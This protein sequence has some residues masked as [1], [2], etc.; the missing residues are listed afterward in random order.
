MIVYAPRDEIALQNI[1][2]IAQLGLDHPIAIRYPRGRGFI[3]DWQSQYLAKYEKIEIGKSICLK[4]GSQIAVLSCGTIGNNVTL[5]ISKLKHPQTIAH[6]DFSFVKPLDEI[7]LHSIFEKYESVITIEDGTVKGG[8]GSAI[9]EFAAANHYH[10]QIN[11][12]GIPDEFIE[13]GTV[14][15]LQQ[16]CKIDVESLKTLFSSY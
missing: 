2:Y 1:L 6:Y 16:L 10:S 3:T 5:A 13:H 8:F 15:E 14:A 7:Q 11:V 4:E 9:V 12:L